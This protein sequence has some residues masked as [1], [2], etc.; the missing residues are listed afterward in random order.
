MKNWS[1]YGNEA[2]TAALKNSV[3]FEERKERANAFLPQY[4]ESLGYSLTKNNSC[5]IC[6]QGENTPCMHYY[7]DSNKI[8]C[9]SCGATA[10]ALDVVGAVEGI[11]DKW[12]QLKHLESLYSGQIPKAA[13]IKKKSAAIPPEEWVKIC[14]E[15]LEK[16]SADR[17]ADEY[18]RSRGLSDDVIR[19]FRLGFERQY[20]YAVIP[21]PNENYYF[22]R[23]ISN[24]NAYDK[25]KPTAAEAGQQPI[26][27]A[28]ALYEGGICF[29]CEGALDALS[30]IECGY[31][32]I[33]LESAENGRKLLNLLQARPTKARLIIATDNDAAGNKTAEELR[34]VCNGR[35]KFPDGVKDCNEF[36]I[37]DRKEFQK[38]LDNAAAQPIDE[39]THENKFILQPIGAYKDSFINELHTNRPRISSGYN[40]LDELLCGGFENELYMLYA[41]SG[42]GKSTFCTNIAE[43]IVLKNDDIHVI[44][45]G[46]EM[47]AREF[48]ARGISRISYELNPEKSYS[49]GDILYYTKDTSGNFTKL[50]PKEY[51]TATETY[52][53]RYG[54]RLVIVEPTAPPTAEFICN[55]AMDYQQAH[56][57]K[58]VVFVDY[59]QY[60]APT[61]GI[62][63]DERMQL[64]H[65]VRQL[66]ILSRSIPVVC[67]SS[68]NRQSSNS[69]E[70]ELTSAKGSGLIEYTA[71]IVWTMQEDKEYTGELKP[72][73]YK[74]DY[75]KVMKLTTI[76][77]RNGATGTPINFKFH[78]ARNTFEEIQSRKTHTIPTNRER[79]MC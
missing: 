3:E 22:K 27:N 66:K 9:F 14:A 19:R 69:G 54:D 6:G 52:F 31:N 11:T 37:K 77:A 13:P 25:S 23:R 7:A 26:F 78:T 58:V 1:E 36:L 8:H 38:M 33:S 72:T 10:D 15:R 28:A 65:A 59:L 55:S 30:V 74:G 24:Y 64:D 47:A 32:A 4:L 48:Y 51:E 2:A 56:N 50:H 67:I 68:I 42:I 73:P 75:T 70:L 20:N 29:I 57:C 49:T 21:Y 45:Y 16:W 63:A 40:N 79:K 18:F 35:V 17:G 41:S 5:P 62:G 76:K 34:S 60:I 44:Y 39:Q 53:K 46:L 12:E 71:S 43:N 61:Q